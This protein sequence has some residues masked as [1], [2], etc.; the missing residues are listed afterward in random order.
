MVSLQ[1]RCMFKMSKER[2]IKG[3]K[4]VKMS[5]D[6]RCPMC[7]YIHGQENWFHGQR[8]LKDHLLD[9][10]GMIKRHNINDRETDVKE[11]KAPLLERK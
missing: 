10:H 5:W 7:F 9:A 11:T 4:M 6:Y 2:E 3:G 8:A 1:R